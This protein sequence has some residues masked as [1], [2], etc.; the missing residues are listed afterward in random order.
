M[1]GQCS[2]RDRGFRPGEIP[3][4]CHR[5]VNHLDILWHDDASGTIAIVQ[6]DSPFD[7]Q[8]LY[9]SDKRKPDCF[10]FF[11]VF[12]EGQCMHAVSARRANES[13]R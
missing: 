4:I 10:I 12:N 13:C 11:N 9:V 3:L 6:P 2:W 5:D 7:D 1:P 8:L